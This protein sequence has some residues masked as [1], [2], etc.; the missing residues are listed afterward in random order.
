MTDTRHDTTLPGTACP[1][2]TRGSGKSGGR[3]KYNEYDIS[4]FPLYCS[5]SALILT[6]EAATILFLASACVLM[7]TCR[8]ECEVVSLCRPV[9][10]KGTPFSTLSVYCDLHRTK[11][12]IVCCNALNSADTSRVHSLFIEKNPRLW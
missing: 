8:V 9:L 11:P 7:R 6:F 12:F 2:T 10:E 4:F 5:F 1:S 3:T